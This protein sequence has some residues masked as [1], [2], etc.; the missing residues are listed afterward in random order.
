MIKTQVQIPDDL[1][2]KAKQVAKERELSFA[3]VMRRGLEYITQTYLPEPVP[4]FDLPVL[5]ASSFKVDSDD[6]DFK[7]I[8]A[9]EE[10]HRGVGV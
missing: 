6:I 3:E 7:A 8:T 2:R 4:E 1:Y 5:D 10:S 9:D